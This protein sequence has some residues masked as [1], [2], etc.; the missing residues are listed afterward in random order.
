M[1]TIFMTEN[2]AVINNLL[3]NYLESKGSDAAPTVVFL[4]GW[5]V[6]ASIWNQV[7]ERLNRLGNYNIYALD[8]PGFG[9]SQGLK[10]NFDLEGYVQAVKGFIEKLELKNVCLVGHSFG[11][12]IAIKFSA[13]YP[14]FVERLVLVDSAGFTD[15]S[16]RKRFIVFLSKFFG[17]LFYL[18]VI[19][20]LR[21][22]FYTIIGSDYFNTNVDLRPTFLKIVNEDLT[23]YLPKISVL[24]LIIWGEDDGD[25]PLAFAEKLKANIAN[26]ELKI[27]EGAEHISFLDKPDEFV[28]ELIKFLSPGYGE[29]LGE[30]SK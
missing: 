11:G 30:R 15:K 17:P 5:L 27:L 10:D 26:S 2:Q 25:T 1:T 4:H 22:K 6:K 24:T 29:R 28:E 13:E 7:I 19:K 12:R 16:F 21:P 14:E 9:K 23:E 3:I 8:L 18:P 20:L